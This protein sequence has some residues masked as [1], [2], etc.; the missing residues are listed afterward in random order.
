MAEFE[1]NFLM[2]GLLVDDVGKETIG[3]RTNKGWKWISGFAL[4]EALDEG[5]RCL[6][7]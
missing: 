6:F 4:A 5:F 2:G 3:F 1:K 7:L